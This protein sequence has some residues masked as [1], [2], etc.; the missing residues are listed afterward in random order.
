MPIEVDNTSD[1]VYWSDGHEEELG[2]D[3][4][5]PS[6][7]SSGAAQDPVARKGSTTDTVSAGEHS[8]V[9]TPD[10]VANRG[11][12]IEKGKER[13]VDS[14]VS[15]T[16]AITSSKMQ[17]QIFTFAKGRHCRRGATQGYDRRHSTCHGRLW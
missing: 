11:L 7:S 10:S 9:S 12:S 3:L 14:M 8:R 17:R 4:F 6:V 5:G 15:T 13:Q 2:D 1:K 16:R